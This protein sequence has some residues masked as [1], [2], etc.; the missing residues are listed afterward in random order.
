[1]F[2][3]L[4]YIT[5]NAT[6][7]DVLSHRTGIAELSILGHDSVSRAD[8]YNRLKEFAPNKPFRTT[9]QYSNSMY[10]VAGYIVELLTGKQWEDF[11]AENIFHPLEM[12]N[13]DFAFTYDWKHE[14]RS[15]LYYLKDGQI[16]AYPG[17][18]K[19]TYDTW[20]PAGS[21][22]SSADDM[23]KWLMFLLNGGKYKNKNLISQENFDTIISPHAIAWNNRSDKDFSTACYCLGWV[24][25]HYKGKNILWHNGTL[26]SYIS[27]MPDQNIGISILTNLNSPLSK[28]LTHVIYDL[29][30]TVEK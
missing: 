5:E 28:E 10:A 1:M 30:M 13:S 25:Q 11:V 26:G 15:K 14:N 23:C 12:N 19:K 9:F 24:S 20:A 7:I 21:I 16:N 6:I 2:H 22:N 4:Q 8:V 18:D 17:S 29:I 3:R 27:F